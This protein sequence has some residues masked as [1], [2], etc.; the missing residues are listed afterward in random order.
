[1]CG[2]TDSP[3]H[4]T[5]EERAWLAH[6]EQLWRQARAI[7]EQNRDLDAGDVYH[8]LR[9]LELPAG[10][11]LRLGLSRGRLGTHRR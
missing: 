8:A 1:L 2:V 9:C 5:V 6:S 7:V 3:A 11:R 10:E 4:L